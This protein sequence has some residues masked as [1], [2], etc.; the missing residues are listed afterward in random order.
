MLQKS[1][2]I[3]RWI[4]RQT[5]L[6]PSFTE[7]RNKVVLHLLVKVTLELEDIFIRVFQ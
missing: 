4:Y 5:Y 6:Q 3:D 2:L 1:T 7:G